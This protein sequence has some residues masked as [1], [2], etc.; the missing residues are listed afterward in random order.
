[1]VELFKFLETSFGDLSITKEEIKI[2]V[3]VPL[4]KI[5][6]QIQLKIPTVRKELD[7]S[8]LRDIKMRKMQE[9]IDSV[10]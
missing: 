7:E 5:K 2:E 9:E 6:K 4:G 10:K 3:E 8:S 1:M